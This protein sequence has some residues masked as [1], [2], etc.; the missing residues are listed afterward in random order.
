M[1]VASMAILANAVEERIDAT[2]GKLLLRPRVLLGIASL[3]GW[4]RT[5]DLRRYLISTNPVVVMR[6]Y[7]P[8]RD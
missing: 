5:G 6:R 8:A 4:L 7:L 3:L 1:A 2:V